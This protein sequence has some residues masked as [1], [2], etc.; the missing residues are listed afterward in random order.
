MS[1]FAKILC[2]ALAFCWVPMTQHC[3]LEA[4]GMLPC[5]H[6]ESE[7]C[8]DDACGV[9]ESRAYKVSDGSVKLPAPSIHL[10]AWFLLVELPQGAESADGDIPSVV[11]DRPLNWVPRWQ[12]VQRA[13]LPVR[14]PSSIA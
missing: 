2:I 12:F 7:A 3:F 10:C 5:G 1:R 4:A 14:A 9:S 8:A 6:G 13:A 11:R